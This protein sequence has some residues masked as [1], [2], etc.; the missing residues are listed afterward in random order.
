ML[1]G[2]EVFGGE[3][4]PVIIGDAT[5]YFGDAIEIL[6]TIKNVNCLVTDPPYLLTYG[7][8]HGSMGGCLSLENYDNKGGLVDCDIDWSDFMP[9]LYC[10]LAD[11][12]H[13]YIM[14][15]NRHV[16][17]MLNAAENAGFR[18]HNLLVWDKI[19]AT[20]NRWYMKNLEFIGFFYKGAAKFINDCSAK[21]LIRCA[22]VDESDHPTEKPVSLME[23]YIANSTQS[24]EI[25]CDPFMGSG[26]TG[27]AAI[28]Q[29]RKFIG[30]EKDE[31]YF[32]IACK[33]IEESANQGSLFCQ[34]K[35]VQNNKINL[36]DSV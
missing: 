15:N 36:F 9:L 24:G 32:Q 16:Q 26:T 27:V 25:I 31:K 2:G 4:N 7:G 34:E 21:Q 8:Q 19:S 28:K 1:H 10:T 33:R 29:G 17:A 13:A 30:I 5:L 20:P 23:H 18:F 3:M 6:P 22:Q 35:K 14:A 11:Q 12:A